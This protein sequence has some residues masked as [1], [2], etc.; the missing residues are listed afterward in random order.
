MITDEKFE[1]ARKFLYLEDTYP[2][3]HETRKDK[4][5][6]ILS[7]GLNIEKSYNAQISRVVSIP[8]NEDE[9][10][11]YNYYS[12][13][14]KKTIL[15]FGIPKI[16]LGDVPINSTYAHLILNCIAEFKKPEVHSTDGNFEFNQ[17]R[18]QRRESTI[19]TKWMVGYFDE[20]NNFFPNKNYI[21]S[22]E[23]SDELILSS[24]KEILDELHKRYPSIYLYLFGDNKDTSSVIPDDLDLFHKSDE[25]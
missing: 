17:L 15:V 14:L 20:D 9:F 6:N 13:R 1:E 24:K 18:Y 3:L 4:I 5:D 21:M 23:N 8:K 25:R 11:N 12:D 16:I 7:E 10:K 2:L 19:P 22:Q